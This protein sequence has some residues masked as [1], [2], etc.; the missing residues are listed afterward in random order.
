MERVDGSLCVFSFAEVDK[1]PDP[2]LNLSVGKDVCFARTKE[3]YFMWGNFS[4]G[5]NNKLPDLKTELEE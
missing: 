2:V 4:N 3:Q 1:I 5:I